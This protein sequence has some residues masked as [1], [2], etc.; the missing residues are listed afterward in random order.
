MYCA[1]WSCRTDTKE[2][3]FSGRSKVIT[4]NGYQKE[5]ADV[6]IGEEVLVLNGGNT[7]SFEPIF[8]FIHAHRTGMYTF[9]RL[10]AFNAQANK[11]VSIEISFYHL[12]FLFENQYPIHA[13]RVR[14]GDLL[15]IVDGIN[16]LPGV[17]VK[18][19]ETKSEG[20]LSPLTPSGTIVI[21]GIVASNYAVV[22]SHLVAHYVMQPYR[23]WRAFFGASRQNDSKINT[24]ATFF[25]KFSTATGLIN[26]L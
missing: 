1:G 11:T 20:F 16:V 25:Y 10:T 4:K 24:Y 17:V 9:L 12:I 7:L 13:S 3:C 21:D 26:I 14:I 19:E 5:L 8:D 15:Q 2:T 22:H 18:I 6:K 23:W